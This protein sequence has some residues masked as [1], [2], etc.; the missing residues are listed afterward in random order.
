MPTTYTWQFEVLDV[1]PTYETVVNAVESMHWQLIADDGAGHRASAC[2]ETKTGSVDV[3][4]FIPFGDLTLEVVQ[5]WCE[6]AIGSQELDGI[7]AILAGQ[8]NDLA[9]PVIYSYPPPWL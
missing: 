9:N 8:V 5:G 2:G 4:N 1:F 7:K 6:A 3:E